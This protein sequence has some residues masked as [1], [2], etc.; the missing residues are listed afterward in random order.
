MPHRTR[1]SSDPVRRRYSVQRF[2]RGARSAPSCPGYVHPE[3]VIPSIAHVGAV[4]IPLF[5]HGDI[6]FR[7]SI[8]GCYLSVRKQLLS[9]HSSL[10]YETSLTVGSRVDIYACQALPA[11]ARETCWTPPWCIPS[12]KCDGPIV[13]KVRVGESS[14]CPTISP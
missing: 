1:R 6:A 3:L 8:L 11:A 13:L 14:F 10:S 12:W 5:I 7:I 2:C 9:V 4:D